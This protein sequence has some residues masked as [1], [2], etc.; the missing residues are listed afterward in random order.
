[1]SNYKFVAPGILAGGG[2]IVNSGD[3]I[4]D[5]M[6]SEESIGLMLKS[7]KVI[8]VSI[9]I[10]ASEIAESKAKEEADKKSKESG[11]K[12]SGPKGK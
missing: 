11:N 10:K 6:I 8:D 3:L 1:M 9:E 7:G 5:G 12:N 4:P 2:K